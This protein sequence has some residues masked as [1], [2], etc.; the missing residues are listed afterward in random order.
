[1]VGA[2]NTREKPDIGVLKG[3]QA[4]SDGGEVEGFGQIRDQV[5]RVVRYWFIVRILVLQGG[6]VE[7]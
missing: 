7:K 1:V 5:F 4:G 3:E 2:G 6:C